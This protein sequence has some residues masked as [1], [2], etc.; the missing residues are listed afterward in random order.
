MGLPNI[1]LKFFTQAVSA[2]TRSQ[3][4][5]V[6]IIIRD[7]KNNG[8]HSLTPS[9]QIPSELSE[10]N[11]NYITRAFLGYVNPP[12]KVIVYV[13]PLESELADALSYFETQKYDYLVGPYDISQADCTTIVNFIK[14]QYLNG[15][16]FKA[17]LPH[18]TAD[19]ELIINFDTDDNKLGDNI[20]SAAEYCSRIAGLI[21]GTPMTISC[22]YAPLL[23]LMDVERL[24]KVQMDAAI[25]AGKFILLHDGEKVKAARGINSFVTTTATKGETY[26]KIKIVEA[27]HMIT[28]DIKKTVQ[29]NYI[30]KYPNSYDNKCLLISAIKGYFLGLEQEGILAVGTS[31]VGIDLVAQ[32]NYLISNGINT[33]DMDEEAIKSANTGDKVFLS[34]SLSILD[35]IEDID[36]NITI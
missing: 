13:L 16:T 20:Y 12:R 3:K 36:L 9:S 1:N 8:E 2:I 31:Q 17:V 34:A 24:N 26:K 11:K 4:G 18:T 7:A 23:E 21:A 35:A 33:E 10:E 19:S 6:A 14:N 28:N 5:I 15:N 30:G 25:D 29:D 27:I 22:T 32:E